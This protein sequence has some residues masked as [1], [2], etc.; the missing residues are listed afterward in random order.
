[1]RVTVPVGIVAVVL[2]VAG[3]FAREVL[4]SVRELREDH[5]RMGEHMR[6]M[7]AEIDR[8]RDRIDRSHPLAT[9]ER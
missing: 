6:H 5:A 2:A 1:M 8:L 3:Y 9:E 7:E 4:E